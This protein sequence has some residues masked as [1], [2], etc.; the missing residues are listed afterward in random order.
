MD[1]FRSYAENESVRY[2]FYHSYCPSD[3]E[4]ISKL[5]SIVGYEPYIYDV[6]PEPNQEDIVLKEPL[7]LITKSGSEMFVQHGIT[8]ACFDTFR[9]LFGE[10]NE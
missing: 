7:S 9:I 8:I 5:K 4:V 1:V 2:V 3:G 10:P 6:F